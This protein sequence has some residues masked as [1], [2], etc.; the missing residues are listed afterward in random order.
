M[1]LFDSEDLAALLR[2]RPRRQSS[3]EIRQQADLA[4]LRQVAFYG[5]V[6][7]RDLS[8]LHP[9]KYALQSAQRVVQRLVGHS[10]PL[11]E[12]RSNALGGI[13]VVLT[14]DG[15]TFLE[16]CGTTMARHGM[17]LDSVA[18]PTFRHHAI[19]TRFCQTQELIGTTAWTEY[20]IGVGL[21]ALSPAEV[22]KLCGKRPDALLFTPDKASDP[23]RGGSIYAVE[24]EQARKSKAVLAGCLK[25]AERASAGASVRGFK[26][27][28]LVFV[29]DNHLAHASRIA[30]AAEMAWETKTAEER[31][32]L[33]KLVRLVSVDTRPPLVFG[34]W[35]T[36]PLKI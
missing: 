35:K 28:G 1:R 5:H 14:P 24:V 3:G 23:D 18:G 33:A 36:Q 20:A 26:L 22:W 27:R 10:P 17:D 8:L 7:T 9:G 21:A 34:E 16:L 30:S 29:F 13:S 31:A 15:A 25:Q 2:P 32:R 12:R 4:A 19:T 6:T 11:L